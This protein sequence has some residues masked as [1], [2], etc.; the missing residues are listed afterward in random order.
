MKTRYFKFDTKQQA[1]E[2]AASAGLT[3]TDTNGA[4]YLIK[5]TH[6]YSI[7]VLCRYGRNAYR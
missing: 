5:D 7:D 3:G 1:F 6:Q 4:A 2:L